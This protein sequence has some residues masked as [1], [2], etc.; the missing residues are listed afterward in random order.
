MAQ[1]DALVLHLVKGVATV[2]SE[3][4]ELIKPTVAP[5]CILG[6]NVSAECK[7]VVID[8]LMAACPSI[9]II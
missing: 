9:D 4:V 1:A 3:F 7:A 2:V 5:L 8:Q 6:G